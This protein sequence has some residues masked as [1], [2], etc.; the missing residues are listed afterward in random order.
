ML[1]LPRMAIVL[2]TFFLI[3]IDPAHPQSEPASQPVH[4]SEEAQSFP[5]QTPNFAGARKLMQQGKYDE[6]L[7]QLQ[8]LAERNP[9]LAGLSHELGAAYYKKGDF[10]KAAGYLKQAIEENP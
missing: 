2:L 7:S 4:S 10:L 9:K 3:A 5:P 6:A 1:A 8:G